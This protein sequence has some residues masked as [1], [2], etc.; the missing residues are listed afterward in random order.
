M[1][2]KI[3]FAVDAEVERLVNN[4]YFTEKKIIEDNRPLLDHLAKILVEQ[5]VVSVEEFAM[6]RAEFSANVTPF[7]IIGEEFN[8]DQMPFNQFT[9]SAVIIGVVG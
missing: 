8:R 4:F 5:E 9:A 1:G 6:M 3:I 7:E 2:L